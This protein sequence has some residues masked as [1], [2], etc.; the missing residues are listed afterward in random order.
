M[1]LPEVLYQHAQDGKLLTM[2]GQMPMRQG[3]QQLYAPYF[4]A[5]PSYTEF[6][7]EAAHDRGARRAEL[8]PGLAGLPRCLVEVGH[9]RPAEPRHAALAGAAAQINKLIAATP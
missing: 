4:T 8:D 6:A 7:T 1:E 2:T 9:T 3:I 5:N